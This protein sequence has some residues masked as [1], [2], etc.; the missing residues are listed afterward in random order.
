VSQFRQHARVVIDGV[1]H[2]IV[3]SAVDSVDVPMN[4]PTFGDTMRTVWRACR[5]LKVEGCPERYEVFLELLDDVDMGDDEGESAN[6]LDPT[7]AP[8]S[9]G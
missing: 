8:V 4:S 7:P 6:G 1:S 3:T 2:D 5:R 9:A